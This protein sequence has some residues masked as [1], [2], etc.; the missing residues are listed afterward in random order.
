MGNAQKALIMA[1]GFFLAIALITIAVVM[2]IS[3]QDATK[4]AQNNF[5]DIQTELSQTAFTVYDNTVVS[6]SQV[7]NALRKFADKE[8]FGI[9][10]QTGKNPVGSWYTNKI[11]TA[12]PSS[13]NYGTVI[14]PISR[15]AVT[16]ATLESHVDYVNPSGKFKARIIKDKSNV[17]RALEFM[18]Q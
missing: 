8:Q 2:F 13:S 1:A 15:D 11:D 4:A 7:V 14:S 6:G 16:N 10:V 9:Q 18:Q 17:I 5:S 3:A 12:S